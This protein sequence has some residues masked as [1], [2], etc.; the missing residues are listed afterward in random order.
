L[1]ATVV[2]SLVLCLVAPFV[3]GGVVAFILPA[4]DSSIDA[5]T[6]MHYASIGAQGYSRALGVFGVI[7]SFVLSRRRATLSSAVIPGT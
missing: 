2:S 7:V 4:T 5:D 6:V 3:V 1:L